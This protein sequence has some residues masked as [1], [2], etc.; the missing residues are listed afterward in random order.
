MLKHPIYVI[1]DSITTPQGFCR[2][3]QIYFK[4]FKGAK[5]YKDKYRPDAKIRKIKS[6]N[7]YL[8]RIYINN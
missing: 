4:T 7:Q 2:K 5:Y 6:L 8:K 1:T 3:G